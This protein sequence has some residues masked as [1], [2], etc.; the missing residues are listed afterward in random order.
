[1]VQGSGL[2]DI[3]LGTVLRQEDIALSAVAEDKVSFTP[4]YVS[5]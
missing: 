4:I 5:A 3:A 2:V 1:M